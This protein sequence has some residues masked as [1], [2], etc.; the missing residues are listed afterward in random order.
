MNFC[1]NNTHRKYMGLKLL[2]PNYDLKIIKKGDYD[3]YYLFFNDSKIVKVIHYNI[4][5]KNIE[6]TEEDVNYDT[7]QN[8]SIVLPK[9]FRGKNRK[10]SG[11]VIDAFNSEGNYFRISMPKGKKYGYVII[12][13]STSQRT[14]F[15]DGYVEITPDLEGIEKWCDDFVKNSTEKDLIEVEEFSKAKRQQIAYKEGD[16]FRVK[17][18]RDKY[19]YGRILL[20]IYQGIKNKTLNYWDKFLGRALIV[21]TFHILT[22]RKDVSIEELKTLKIFPAQYIMDNNLFY[23]DYEIIGNDTLPAQLAY[24]I[25][26][27]EEIEQ[28]SSKKI[29]FQ[30]GRIHKEMEY[31]ADKYYGDFL[32][33]GIGFNIYADERLIEQCLKEKSNNPY[34]ERYDYYK[35]LRNPK[36]K[37][38]LKKVLKEFEL[39]NLMKIYY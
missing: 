1:L 5:D 33:N 22:E 38:I 8:R 36:Y 10:L 19:T 39:E 13:N 4:S 24:P 15:Y 23:G 30:C 11:S 21:E 29:I 12:G 28:D 14:F 17:L 3:E 20:D 18:G 37:D 6:M 26:Y 34:W 25:M 7:I 27:G 35:D 31:R 32:N 9:T 16:Y 2:K